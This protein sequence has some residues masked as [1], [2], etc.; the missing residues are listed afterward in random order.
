MAGI[1]QAAMSKPEAPQ[2]NHDQIAAAIESQ[3]NQ[4]PEM[5]VKKITDGRGD[6][7][8]EMADTAA[9]LVRAQVGDQEL[10]ER[11]LMRLCGIVIASLMRFAVGAKLV[12]RAD[13]KP[14]GQRATV[15][16]EYMVE[17]GPGSLQ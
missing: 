13:V 8:M 2:Q 1:V 17:N 15:M 14:L 10:D 4:F 12:Q 3:V 11:T 16:A 7:E 9:N 5:I 6:L